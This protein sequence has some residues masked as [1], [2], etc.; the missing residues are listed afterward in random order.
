M[1]RVFEAIGGCLLMGGVLY[2]G[3]RLLVFGHEWGE[4]MR[5]TGEGL[6]SIFDGKEKLK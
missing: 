5:G 6:I 2:L 4:K 3:W 1:W